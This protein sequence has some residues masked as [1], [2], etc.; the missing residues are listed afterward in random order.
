MNDIPLTE[1]ASQNIERPHYWRDVRDMIAS[2]AGPEFENALFE[3]QSELESM[4][5]ADAL[6]TFH[7]SKFASLAYTIKTV[8]DA[9]K[10]H[11]FTIRQF[12]G[13]LRG[14]GPESK[15]FYTLPVC[16]KV[17]H[18]ETQ[19]AEMVIVDIPVE[20]KAISYGAALTF[21][22]R[23]ALQSY[24]CIASADSDAMTFVQN[25][26]DQESNEETAK[27]LITQIEA[28]ESE[29]EFQKYFEMAD[30]SLKMYSE[31]VLSLVRAASKEHLRKL[32]IEEENK[33]SKSKVTAKVES[34]PLKGKANA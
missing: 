10:N 18:S 13:A 24:F 3:L 12:P 8:R 21:G 2:D 34:L 7:E 23:Y 26:I 14:H 4:L 5:E 9:C 30:A 25:K 11:G 22:K 17:T 28:T 19:Q 29:K 32:K 6:N 31:G 33:K 27:T 15:R 16:T 1:Q 20:N